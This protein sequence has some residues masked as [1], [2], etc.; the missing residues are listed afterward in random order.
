MATKTYAQEAKTIMNRYK[1]RLGDK[2]DKG[3]KL[4]LEAM[5][6]ELDGLRESQETERLKLNGVPEEYC[7]GGKLR[8][9]MATGGRIPMYQ[10]PGEYP[11]WLRG[12]RWD[13]G[14]LGLGTTPTLDYFAYG[15]TRFGNSTPYAGGT[16][17]G[18]PYFN[19]LSAESSLRQFGRNFLTGERIN[20]GMLNGSGNF[21]NIPSS[22]LDF[23]AFNTK[24]SAGTSTPAVAPTPVEPIAGMN[25]SALASAFNARK[26]ANAG[27][28]PI[29]RDS[30]PGT[31]AEAMKAVSSGGNNLEPFNSRVPWMGAAA[32]IV[33]SLLMNR[34]VD[35]PTYNYEEYKPTQIAPHLVDY[36]RGREQT[37]RE[38]DLANNII[39]RNARGTGS[40]AG[41]MENILAG[42]T[43]TQRTT[44]TAFNQ[45]LENQQNTNAQIL[46]DVGARNAQLNLSATE[47]NARN[48]LYA[49]QIERENA[50]FNE[51]QRQNRIG[52]IID[53]ITGYGRDLMAADQYD[54]MLQILAPDN[55]T[56]YASKDSRLRRI[57]QI[58]PKMNLRYRKTT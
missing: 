39:A 57:L 29:V 23:S 21:A 53:S 9:K 17:V 55:Y 2:F 1:I 28:N 25:P 33:G 27:L 3:D 34:K 47:M 12:R 43:G 18:S 48:K 58:S 38:R 30:L 52:S 7:G 45:S 56:P 42:T 10:G 4:S 50:L 32:N 54:Q 41:L 46:N 16:G 44:G 36:T 35:L 19:N 31:S 26:G 13:Q 6:K 24:K 8:L 15:D 5:N 49:T 14:A 40:Q 37:M 20:P 22:T 11:N 51:Q